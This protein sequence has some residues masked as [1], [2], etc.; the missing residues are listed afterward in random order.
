MEEGGW[1]KIFRFFPHVCPWW[2][3]RRGLLLVVKLHQHLVVTDG[4]L[5]TLKGGRMF[6]YCYL[7]GFDSPK[8]LSASSHQGR[9]HLS[10][11]YWLTKFTLV[12]TQTQTLAA[13]LGRHCSKHFPCTNA[14]NSM[15]PYLVG[16][17]G[18]LNVLTS[19]QR[20]R[21]LFMISRLLRNVLDFNPC[22]LSPEQCC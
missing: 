21:N 6:W 20:T 4:I 3:K 18:I 16:L 15:E 1:H 22:S 19:K 7:S 11:V 5:E 9:K 8:T 2:E 17:V 14:W 10:K 13:K 12:Q